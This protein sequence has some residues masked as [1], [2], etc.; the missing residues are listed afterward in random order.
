V[1]A[2]QERELARVADRERATAARAARLEQDEQRI[3]R[4]M[5]SLGA[6]S[7]NAGPVAGLDRAAV[8]STFGAPAEMPELTTGS[9]WPVEGRLLYGFG[10]APQDNGTAIRW[11]G[12]GIA[13]SE[14]T[15]VRAVAQ[16]RVVM[17]GP[18][19]G[20][21]PTVVVSHGGGYYSL[22]LYLGQ[23]RVREG[24]TVNESQVVGTVGNSGAQE[25]P[26]IEF[27]IRGPAGEAVDP[28]V[29][30]RERLQG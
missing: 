14:G 20:Y 8:T 28:L 12:I 1:L 9:Q 26:H 10:R 11:N 6:G 22:Y 29:W 18:F 19:D 2:E 5:A 25:G 21:G 16:G 30:L 23:I 27:Q 17:A 24:E 13:A 3:R 4:L 15:A 7:G